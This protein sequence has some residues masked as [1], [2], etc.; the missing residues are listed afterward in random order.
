M[1]ALLLK[2][3]KLKPMKNKLN[4]LLLATAVL[5]VIAGCQSQSSKNALDDVIINEE[6]NEISF[7]NNNRPSRVII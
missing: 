6:T 2:L 7:V 5:F 4:F 3:I 1:Q